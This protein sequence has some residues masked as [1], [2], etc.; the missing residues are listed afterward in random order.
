[1]GIPVPDT[2]SVT[3]DTDVVGGLLITNGDIDYLIGDDTG[4]WTAITNDTSLGF[5]SSFSM[6]DDGVW[7]FSVDNDDPGI[8]ELNT[9]ESLEF[10]YDVVSANGNSTVTITVFGLDEPPCFARGTLIDTPAGP[11]PIETL[12]MGDEILTTDGGPVKIQWIGSKQTSI[13]EFP[14]REKYA[15]IEIQPG[16]FGPGVPSRLL[17]VS[18]EH[19]IVLHGPETQLL[20]GESEVLCAAKSLV[21]GSTIIQGQ[22][23]DVE[24]F[25]FLLEKH[26]VITAEGCKSESLYPGRQGLYRFDAAEQ[27]EIFSLFPELH[28]LPESYGQSARHILRNFEAKLLSEVQSI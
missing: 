7:N 23:E 10:Q 6:D 21:N 5:G 20:F 13:A 17:I 19:R 15:S 4:D 24:Y 22:Q 9:G 18:P 1:M 16:A 25:H 2:G 11:R 27:E 3:E 14:E 26:S 12:R 28:C 8:Q